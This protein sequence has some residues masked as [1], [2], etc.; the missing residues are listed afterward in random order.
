MAAR[1]VAADHHVIAASRF[2]LSAAERN[3]K[4]A[5]RRESDA[6]HGKA[7]VRPALLE[8]RFPAK[9]HLNGADECGR[10]AENAC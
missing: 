10:D 3:H 1:L 2:S 6:C 4:H 9:R 5:C 8:R 7:N